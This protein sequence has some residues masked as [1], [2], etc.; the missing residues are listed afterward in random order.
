MYKEKKLNRNTEVP[1]K[2][3]FLQWILVNINSLG[4]WGESIFFWQSES[5]RAP[6]NKKKMFP[7]GSKR[8]SEIISRDR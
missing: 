4:N 2:I 6:R 5:L 3:M 8:N 7:F 1:G